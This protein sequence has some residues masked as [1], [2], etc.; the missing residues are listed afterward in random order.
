MRVRECGRKERR[1][2]GVSVLCAHKT[3][4]FFKKQHVPSWAAKAIEGCC[5][6]RQQITPHLSDKIRLVR[7]D[8]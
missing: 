5:S 3:E 8:R 1:Q 6:E 2:E 7:L 4:D